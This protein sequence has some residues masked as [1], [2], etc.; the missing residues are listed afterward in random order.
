MEQL[1]RFLIVALF[2]ALLVCLFQKADADELDLSGIE[3]H[4]CEAYEREIAQLAET[5]RGFVERLPSFIDGGSY[6]IARYAVTTAKRAFELQ[7]LLHDRMD[8]MGCFGGTPIW[9]LD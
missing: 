5:R 1:L 6:K 4:A 2:V 7:V 8:A 3:N 9:R